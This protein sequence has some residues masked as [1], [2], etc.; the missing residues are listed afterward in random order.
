MHALA[1]RRERLLP[2]AAQRAQPRAHQIGRVVLAAQ[3]LLLVEI[4]EH[5]LQ[6]F[7][8][9]AAEFPRTEAIFLGGVLQRSHPQHLCEEEGLRAAR[10]RAQAGCGEVP[11]P[12]EAVG[13]IPVEAQS[14]ARVLGVAFE[15]LDR[16]RERDAGLERALQIGIEAL[17]ECSEPAI[18]ARRE[19]GGQ[20]R[21]L[22]AR[23]EPV[24]IAQ[25]LRRAR[26]MGRHAHRVRRVLS[27]HPA[28][29]R[30]ARE[31]AQEERDRARLALGIRPLP[32]H[33]ERLDRRRHRHREQEPLLLA[34]LATHGK[35]V[36]G[37]LAE[38]LAHAI[39]Q[40]EILARAAR[41]EIR[42][43]ADQEEVPE[44]EA[45]G[46]H[47][48]EEPHAVRPTARGVGRHPPRSRRSSARRAR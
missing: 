15:P 18:R 7:V 43:E 12:S 16:A 35:R 27:P 46:L 1:H 6:D 39:P 28:G 42:V 40:K 41:Q 34:R 29:R 13:E 31:F 5:A 36:G 11:L 30:H 10:K 21:G 33:G 32:D 37:C 14:E 38:P 9:E 17:E 44:G 47:H 45:A 19:I 26:R 8:D 3:P 48:V 23:E 20:E 24:A 2:A 4:P 25:V 22:F